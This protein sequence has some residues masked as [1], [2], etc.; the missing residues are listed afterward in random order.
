MNGMPRRLLAVDEP[1]PV[2]VH[3]ENGQSP[4]LIVV[5]HAGNFIPRALGRLGV[6]EAELTRHIA[7]DIGIAAV[8]RFVADALDATLV[9][10]NYSRLVIDCN[11]APGSETSI[12]EISELTPIPGNVGLSDAR[13]DER[14]REIFQP[15]HDRISAEL[16]RRRR[17]GRPAA[18][19]AMHSFTPVFMGAARPW[20]AGV[21]YNRDARFANRLIASLRREDGLIIGDNEPYSVTDES[22]YTIPAHGERRGLPHVEVEIRQDLIAGESGQR[23]WGALLARLL[24]QAYQELTSA[25]TQTT[26]L[27]LP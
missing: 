13:K 12:P 21:L 11:R 17:Q 24:L 19:I 14:L 6:P 26:G 5:D 22:D 16:D 1:G 18:L 2:T 4:F 7:W 8:S 25:A 10:Q 9:Q 15:Y 3:N 20:H 27:A 23:T